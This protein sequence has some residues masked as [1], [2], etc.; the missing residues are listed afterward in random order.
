MAVNCGGLQPRMRLWGGRAA[1]EAK[2]GHRIVV[3][4]DA[5]GHQRLP[6]L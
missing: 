5:L 3:M 1:D 4:D 6:L 2:R